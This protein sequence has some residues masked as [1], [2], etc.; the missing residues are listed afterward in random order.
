LN[1]LLRGE[2]IRKSEGS[3]GVRLNLLSSRESPAGSAITLILDRG[4]VLS[5]PVNK[6]SERLVERGDLGNNALSRSHGRIST[7]HGGLKFL[8]THVREFRDTVNSRFSLGSIALVSKLQVGEEI[9]E[10]ASFDFHGVISLV[11]VKLE[12]FPHVLLVS[13]IRERT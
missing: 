11:E 1:D 13:R 5:T 6:S 12:L 2:N 3:H 8:L 10:S 4:G 7:K 9:G